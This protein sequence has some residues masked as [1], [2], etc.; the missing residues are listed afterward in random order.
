MGP[1]EWSQ[2]WQKDLKYGYTHAVRRSALLLHNLGHALVCLLPRHQIVV[3]VAP[4]RLTL[5]G[6]K[7]VRLIPL[8]P[9]WGHLACGCM[10]ASPAGYLLSATVQLLRQA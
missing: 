9:Y 8:E 7:C 4:L 3:S 2:L 6:S 1:L 5:S 10:A